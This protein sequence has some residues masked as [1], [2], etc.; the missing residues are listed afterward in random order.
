MPAWD[1][2][3]LKLPLILARLHSVKQLS[4]RAADA[5]PMLNQIA[6]DQ[7]KMEK[8]INSNRKSL[9]KVI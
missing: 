8:K 4:E 2:A 7:E 3:A 6:V 1:E 5:K 9:Q